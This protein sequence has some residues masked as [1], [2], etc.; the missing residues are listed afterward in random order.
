MFWT[1]LRG[2]YINGLLNYIIKYIYTE[3]PLVYTEIIIYRNTTLQQNTTLI[4]KKLY[5]QKYHS[6][7]SL[8]N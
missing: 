7:R 5:I 4:Y 1:N 6:K 2:I 8:K 3:I